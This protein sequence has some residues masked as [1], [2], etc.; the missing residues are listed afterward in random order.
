MPGLTTSQI[1]P[2]FIEQFKF[3]YFF[4]RDQL[5]Q[6]ISNLNEQ[7]GEIRKNGIIVDGK[8]YQINFT[9]TSTLRRK[10]Q[11]YFQQIIWLCYSKAFSFKISGGSNNYKLFPL[12]TGNTV[13]QSELQTNYSAGMHWKL[14][15]PHHTHVLVF[16]SV[17][18]LYNVKM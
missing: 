8:K 9:G 18:I 12:D 3:S 5:V 11:T 4:F 16:C 2:F 14:K 6:L 7:K 10:C 15:L 13:L 1:I 17:M